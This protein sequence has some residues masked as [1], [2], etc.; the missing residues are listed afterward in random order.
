L[1]KIGTKSSEVGTVLTLVDIRSTVRIAASEGYSKKSTFTISGLS[2]GGG[3]VG[4]GS[5]YA[6]T[7]EGKL[8]SSA[9]FDAF[10]KMVVALRQYKAQIVKDGLGEGGALAVQGGSTPAA[11]AIETTKD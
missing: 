3:G 6:N 5:A 7:D 9:F 2:V 8:I 10:N 4:G 11:K 1:A